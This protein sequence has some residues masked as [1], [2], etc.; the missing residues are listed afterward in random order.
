MKSRS[1]KGIT[2][3]ELLV[4]VG[5]ISVVTGIGLTYYSKSRKNL[6]EVNFVNVMRQVAKRVEKIAQNPE[7]IAFSAAQSVN[8]RLANCAW[9][10]ELAS[11][12]DYSSSKV[13][14]SSGEITYCDVVDP[15]EQVE[16]NLY[17]PPKDLSNY[18]AEQRI[19]SG[20]AGDSHKDGVWYDIRGK[21]GCDPVKDPY[22]CIIQVKTYFWA[23]CPRGANEI[24][25]EVRNSNYNAPLSSNCYRAQSINIRY[26]VKHVH[27]KRDRAPSA[28]TRLRRQLPSIP[29]DGTF[30]L[31]GKEGKH[32]TEHASPIDVAQLGRY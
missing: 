29:R 28:Q 20:G 26:Q 14:D 13:R 21:R 3:L 1:Q 32:S 5:I 6:R 16:F 15:N 11:E 31:N 8:R 12:K 7:A 19:V 30:W 10:R 17:V 27:K 23:T 25:R 24:R 18:N 22:R 9:T 4:A 2:V